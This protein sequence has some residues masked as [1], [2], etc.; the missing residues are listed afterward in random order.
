MTRHRWTAADIPDLTGRAFVVTGANGGLGLATTRALVAK[1]GHVTLAV[2]DVA[3][4]RAAVA[5]LPPQN[6]DVRRLDLTD[7]ESVGAFADGMTADH[8]RLDVMVN[9]AGVMGPPRTLTASG[10]ELHFAANHLGHFA[11]TT[12]LLGLLAAGRD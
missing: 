7:L 2:R 1:G 6:V 4:G 3:K 11:L 9:N 12:R 5:G 10:H 8:S